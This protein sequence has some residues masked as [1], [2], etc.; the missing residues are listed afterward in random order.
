MI[1][2]ISEKIMK[3]KTKNTTLLEQFKNLMEK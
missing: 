1:L 3:L 2:K